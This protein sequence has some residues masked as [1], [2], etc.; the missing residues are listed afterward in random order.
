MGKEKKR[1]KSHRRTLTLVALLVIFIV[2]IAIGVYQSHQPAQ[3]VQQVPADQ[4][5]K[6][7][8][9]T[10]NNAE[11]RDDGSWIVYDMEFQLQAV[12]GDAHD[13]VVR[14]DIPQAD[15]ENFVIIKKGQSE[16]VQQKA[17][18]QL[19]YLVEI[20]SDGEL[21]FPVE[22]VSREAIGTIVIDLSKF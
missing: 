12:G 2:I 20:T 14:S 9:A 11:P 19:G 17:T 15:P 10:V 6:V 1:R 18:Q 7:V 16:R 5:F 21:P 22:I 13:V 4:Y 3:P 8:S